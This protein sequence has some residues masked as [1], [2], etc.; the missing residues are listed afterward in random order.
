[1]GSHVAGKITV[2]FAA[3]GDEDL[4]LPGLEHGQ[5]EVG[6]GS[7]AK[8]ADSLAA[9]DSGDAKAAESD[10]SGA[11]QR[12]GL[13][14]VEGIRERDGEIGTG[15]G[16]LGIAAVDGVAGEDGRVAEVFVTA[17]TIGTG[18]VDA[19]EPGDADAGAGGQAAS[20]DFANDLVP[21]DY[22]RAQRGEFTLHDVEVGAADAAG[23]DFDEYMTRAGLGM[24]DVDD[25]EGPRG[26]GSGRGEDG[27]AH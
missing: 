26:N 19:S 16:V 7:E 14:V 2:G 27:G 22:V 9:L 23:A 5:S 1:V 25:F 10:D 13:E 11:E 8:Q 21:W 17:E 15:D 4:A 12:G 20:D 3:G 24:R 6:G 18:A